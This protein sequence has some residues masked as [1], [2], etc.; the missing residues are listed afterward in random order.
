MASNGHSG[1]PP[2]EGPS[3]FY[4]WA[5]QLISRSGYDVDAQWS[6]FDVGPWGSG[7]QHNDKLHIS[8]SAYGR[9][10]LVDAGRFAYTGEVARKFRSYARSS[11]GH[12]V[13]LIDGHGQKPGPT[14]APAPL[15]N[16]H[17]TITESFD[18]ASHSFDRYIAVDGE[19]KHTRA[20]FYVR[21]AYWVVVDRINTDRP[22]KIDVLWHWHP[23]CSVKMDN[24]V[25]M[26][27]NKKG[28]LAVIPVSDQK[29]ETTL[30]SGQE[31]PA[32]QGWY[33]R[34]YNVFEPNVASF[35]NTTINGNSTLVW[36]LLPYERNKP[37]VDA[38]VLHENDQGV[39]VEIKSDKITWIMDIPY[40]DSEG[41]RLSTE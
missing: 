40:G 30:V 33:S 36:L 16:S 1:I 37:A 9:D 41:A 38:K 27:N 32:I 17:C 10:L 25:V 12:N 6:F 20:L 7:H 24:S 29:Y 5:G 18:Y 28:N 31:D 26:T 34:E 3:F 14:H 8:I 23:D 22:R 2:V 13:I 39:R 15:N 4:P 19:I 35:Y 21:G 11:A